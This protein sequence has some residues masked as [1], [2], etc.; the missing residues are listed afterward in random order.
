MVERRRFTPAE[1][2]FTALIVGLAWAYLL[3]YF[4]PSLLWL[5]TMISGGDTPSFV[6]PVRHL[7]DTLLPAGN[8]QGWDLGNFGGYA[9]YQFY[10]LPPSLLIIALS[11]VIPFNIA[12]KLVTV[13]GTFLTSTC[14]R[15]AWA[16]LRAW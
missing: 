9:P 5:D 2:A 10:F 14:S 1:M 7:R 3:T 15:K 12:F 6:R 13:A 16:A 11:L 4:R 8:P